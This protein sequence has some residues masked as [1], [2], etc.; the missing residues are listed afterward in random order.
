MVMPIKWRLYMLV[1]ISKNITS[2][3]VKPIIFCLSLLPVFRLIWLGFHDG[4][5]ANPIEFVLRSTGTWTLNF[6]CFTLAIT[7]LRQLSHWNELIKYRR[8]LGLFCFFYAC[9]HLSIWTGIDRQLDWQQISED[10]LKRIYIWFGLSAF[11]LL[12]P[13]ALTSTKNMQKRLGR[14]W[15]ALHRLIYL[16]ALL[17][18][19]HYWLHKAG[20]NDYLIVNI[21]IGVVFI[22]LGWRIG[23]YFYKKHDNQPIKQQQ[24]KT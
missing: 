3:Q 11:L 18:L 1:W 6:L 8:M 13:L 2:R 10:I 23:R 19:V 9:L 17:A 22:L 7:P 21:Y 12:V 16:T 15:G 4:L 20:K 5:T 24:T 14:K